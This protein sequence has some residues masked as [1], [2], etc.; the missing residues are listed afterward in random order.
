[1]QYQSGFHQKEHVDISL[2]EFIKNFIA[3]PTLKLTSSKLVSSY[4]TGNTEHEK[5]NFFEQ[6]KF[7]KKQID[8]INNLLIESN[9]N[10]IE[11]IISAI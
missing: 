9:I 3:I 5:Q 6:N 1:M 4:K 7:N 11:I 2:K 8:L 10:N